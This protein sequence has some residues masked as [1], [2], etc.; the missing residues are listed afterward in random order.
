M[1]FEQCCL[2]IKEGEVACVVLAPSAEVPHLMLGP[3]FLAMG[4][5]FTGKDPQKGFRD[6]T[7]YLICPNCFD[8]RWRSLR[9]LGAAVPSA[10][11]RGALRMAVLPPCAWVIC[12][13]VPCVISCASK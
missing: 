13:A 5:P 12:A 9:G 8:H 10:A 11:C 4:V 3:A 1:S 2:L 7:G 6:M